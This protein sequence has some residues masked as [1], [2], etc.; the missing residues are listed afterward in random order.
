VAI[1]YLKVYSVGLTEH[2]QATDNEDS[3]VVFPSQTCY[4]SANP[5][6]NNT[7]EQ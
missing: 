4:L 3:N 7:E 2:I 1:S 5:L 6:E